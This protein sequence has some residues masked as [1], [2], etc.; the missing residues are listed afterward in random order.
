MSVQIL[1]HLKKKWVVCLLIFE[2]WR[3][4]TYSPY[5]LFTRYTICIYFPDSLVCLLIFLMVSLKEHK[6]L[7]L[8]EPSLPDSFSWIMPLVTYLRKFCF[9]THHRFFPMFSSWS[10]KVVMIEIKSRIHF[11]LI[12][13][14]VWGECL[15]F[16]PLLHPSLLPPSFSSLVF[17]PPPYPPL[18]LLPLLF[19]IYPIALALFFFKSIFSSFK[20]LGTYAEN[21]LTI[22]VKICFWTLNSVPIIYMSTLLP[23]PHVLDYYGFW[24]SF[25]IGS[26]RPLAFFFFFFKI[27]F[28]TSTFAYMFGDQQS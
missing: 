13:H 12:L 1:T 18:F 2:W 21:Q 20:Y 5:K 25:E 22:N 16:L 24:V 6:F 8:I 19:C 27:T 28:G 11:E 14:M 4:F 17:F 15:G 26:V 9:I 10:F 3:F 23:T 7:V